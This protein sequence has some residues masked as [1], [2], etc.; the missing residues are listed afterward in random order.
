[1]HSASLQEMRRICENITGN[2]I[3]I[4]SELKNRPVDMR[5]YITD[6]SKIENEINWHPRWNVETTFTDIFNWIRKNES[7]LKAILN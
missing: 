6:N 1:M 2:K 3:T 4:E 7:E 5:I